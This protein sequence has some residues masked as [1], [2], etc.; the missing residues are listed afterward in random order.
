MDS[1]GEVW[2][3]RSAQP[4]DVSEQ[5][6]SLL[7]GYAPSIDVE[8]SR[9]GETQGIFEL[10]ETGHDGKRTTTRDDIRTSSMRHQGFFSRSLQTYTPSPSS[11][12][13]AVR[14]LGL[15]LLPSFVNSRLQAVAPAKAQELGPTAHLNGVRGIAA[16]F[17]CVY[18]LSYVVYH[19]Q[20]Y[21]HYSENPSDNRHFV[22]LPIVN[23]FYMGHP[24]VAVFYVVSGYSLSLKPLKQARAADWDGLYR[25]L[26]SAVFRR[27][28]R[29]FLPVMA[30]TFLIML[31]IDLGLYEITRPFATSDKYLRNW[32]E[33]HMFQV[34]SWLDQL[35]D[36]Y[37]RF[38][39]EI[40][41]WDF[42]IYGGSNEYDYH[43]WT[44]A[45]EFRC[46]L[47]LFLSQVG[48]LR[49]RP[50]FRVVAFL[51]VAWFGLQWARWDVCLF[52]VGCAMAD[53]DLM[54]M[55]YSTVGWHSMSKSTPETRGRAYWMRHIL[56]GF[57]SVTGLFL[58]AYPEEDGDKSPGYIWLYSCIPQKFEDERQQSRFWPLFGAILYLGSIN[59]LKK[60]TWLFNTPL[61]QYLGQISFGLY[62]V[63]GL[64]IHTFGYWL[65]MMTFEHVFHFTRDD[66]FG[67]AFNTVFALEACI[68]LSACVWAGDIFY[69]AVDLQTLV[70]TRWLENKCI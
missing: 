23:L 62:L 49:L 60:L 64:V 1:L 37:K 13:P 15:F 35:I 20:S 58:M 4:D 54:Q 6:Q 5:G 39:R 47:V 53:L 66:V 43:L 30:S 50:V 32:R 31:A 22:Q 48:L 33:L 56:C 59:N 57:F 10:Q 12:A 19:S 69:R 9:G 38:V 51:A 36:W 17:V 52:L 65:E 26:S 24:W 41:V 14:R 29:L 21:G 16:F 34:G 3:H 7:N 2:H 42:D 8:G 67:T 63:H 25:T 27:G 45:V 46:S 61:I 55:A 40:W 28:F 44:I 18:H 70:F 11:F 68:I